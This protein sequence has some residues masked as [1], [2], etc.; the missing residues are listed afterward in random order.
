MPDRLLEADLT[1]AV[2]KCIFAV[3]NGLGPGFLEKV[4]ENALAFEFQNS[5]IEFE[6]Q[7][8]L[9]VIY[10]NQIVGDYIADMVVSQKILIEI[11]AI[12]SLAA[13][14]SAQ[15]INYL[16]ATGLRLGLLVNFGG[17]RAEIKRFVL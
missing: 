12:K 5:G 9:Q 8:S 6:R 10:K 4:Y 15:I 16:K 7:K 17:I 2:R 11:K 3:H 14:H 13:E 1:Y